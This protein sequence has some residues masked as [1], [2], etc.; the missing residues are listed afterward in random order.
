MS[1][2]RSRQGFTLIELLVVISII[3]ILAGM[4]FPAI[5]MVKDAANKASC[6]N[7]IHQILIAMNTYKI[8]ADDLWPV[9]PTKNDGTYVD[10]FGADIAGTN[11]H[12][13]TI[14]SFQWL[15]QAT[16]YEL[17]SKT[18]ACAANKA[19]APAI[20]KPGT[21]DFIYYNGT[22]AWASTNPDQCLAYMYDW[23]VPPTAK[24]SRV[25]LGDRPINSKMETNHKGFF[26]LGFADGHSSGGFKPDMAQ[27]SSGTI[28]DQN[29]SSITPKKL[30]NKDAS[31]DDVFD[32]ADV[33]T[34]KNVNRAGKGSTTA[35]ALR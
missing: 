25:V 24:A 23:S 15:T 11:G 8:D 21:D 20:L 16:G 3:A 26:V 29:P 2:S 32:G 10:G 1:Q 12:F 19:T 6:G 35:G 22:A 17:T 33:D 34:G 28:Y 27:A 5:T 7:N 14:G 9:R 18:F 30:L 31:N 13:T 4:L